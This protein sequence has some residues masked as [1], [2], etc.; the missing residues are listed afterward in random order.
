MPFEAGKGVFHKTSTFLAGS[1]LGNVFH[2]N[3]R[4]CC[5]VGAAA[6]AFE[7][8]PGVASNPADVTAAPPAN[9]AAVFRKFLL[10]LSFVISTLLFIKKKHLL[11]IN[12]NRYCL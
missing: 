9:N 10:F 1:A 11:H 2:A 4:Y 12:T 8:P 3:V 7:R 5:A 6:N